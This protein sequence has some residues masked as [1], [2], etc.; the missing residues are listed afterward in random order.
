[1]IVVATIGLKVKERSPSQAVGQGQPGEVEGESTE[2]LVRIVPADEAPDDFE[3]LSTPELGPGP[4]GWLFHPDELL[5][6]ETL[7]EYRKPVA[8]IHAIPE[9]RDVALKLS[10]RKLM[11]ALPLAVQL[12]L[13]NRGKEEQQEL[14]RKIREDRSTPLFEIRTKEL[15]RLA[16]LTSSN[17]ERIHE[18]LAEMVGFPFRWNVLGEDGNVEFEALAPFLIRRDKGVRKKHGYTRFAFEPEILLWFLEPRMWANLSWTVMSGIGRSNGPGQEAAFGLYQT[19][20]RYITTP[21][22]MTT[23][24]DLATCIDLVIGPSR[25]VKVDA[26]G[27]KEVVDYK[28]F[29]RRYLIPGLEILNSHPALNHTVEMTEGKSGRRVVTLRFKFIE[30]RQMSFDLPLGWPPASIQYLGDLGYSDKEINDMS[31]LYLYEQVAEALRRLP[32][33][34][35]R[36][37]E[38]GRKIHARKAFFAGILAN[39]AKGEKQS[40]EEEEKLLKEV[41]QRQQQEA[42]EQ[43]IQ[44]LQKKFGIH[45]RTLVLEAMQQL[46]EA[47][48]DALTQ[49]HLSAKPEDRIMYKP[50]ERGHAYLILFCKWLAT[51][52]PELYTEWLPEAKDR[53]FQSWL[54]WQL[55]SR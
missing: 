16:G 50:G 24:F 30:K 38:K 35:Q 46:P 29:K 25:F 8:A 3:V 11:E 18:N 36:Y 20:W 13:R 14:I 12:D 17:M 1:M 2:H 33:A 9:R 45:Q 23:A 53:N 31:Q 51:A 28:D 5:P 48:R 7:K 4:Q 40:A 41:E 19:I 39:V 42:E 34:E 44:T 6:P 15:V 55:A 43:R 26:K 27:N 21:R 37:R 10:A 49:A 32:A 22:K 47:E 54:V 52:R